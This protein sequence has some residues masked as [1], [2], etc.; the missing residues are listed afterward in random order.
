MC[1]LMITFWGLTNTDTSNCVT[2]K[3]NMYEG[4]I[5]NCE[6]SLMIDPNNANPW[7]NKGVAFDKL[8][9][10]EVVIECYDKAI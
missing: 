3:L 7:I 4:T 1:Q 9:L 5:K 2:P 10:Y 6:N 8:G